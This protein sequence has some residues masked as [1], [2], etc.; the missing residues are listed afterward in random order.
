MKTV[1]VVPTKNVEPTVGMRIFGLDVL[2]AMAICT[3]LHQHGYFFFDQLVDRELWHAP[4]LVDGVTLFFVLSGF[5]I[6]RILFKEQAK[7]RLR[8]GSDLLRFWKRRWWRTLPAYF[9]VLLIV[10]SAALLNGYDMP[11]WLWRYFFFLQ[12]LAWPHPGF[13]GEAWSLCVEEW[14]YVLLPVTLLLIGR[15][16]PSLKRNAILLAIAVFI[17]GPLALK[18]WR[19]MHSMELDKLD[20]HFRMI[21]LYRMDNLM[22]GVAAAWLALF[23][24]SWWQR[25]R[26]IGLV[27][28]VVLLVL[29]KLKGVLL[30][31][32]ASFEILA[33]HDLQS[34]GV[35]LCLPWFSTWCPKVSSTITKPIVH[36]ALISY[37]LYLVNFALV[38]LNVMPLLPERLNGITQVSWE[39]SMVPLFVFWSLSMLLASGLYFAF[40][41]PMTAMRD[42]SSTRPDAN[43]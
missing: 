31:H 15:V 21:V 39:R 41:R 36:M 10:I 5:L 23:K 38:Q 30:G 25:S 6:G 35:L 32:S 4:V 29:I 40:E 33:L 28:G 20:S 22:I 1:H 7:G 27:A 18:H 12:N 9:L 2:R 8:N 3:V 13:F 26:L 16:E 37:S 43:G 24:T 34:V 42:R 19:I 17:L 14:F 11:D